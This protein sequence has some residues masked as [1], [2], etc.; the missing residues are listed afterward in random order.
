VIAG[1]NLVRALQST[2]RHSARRPAMLDR[3]RCYTWAEFGGRVARLAGALRAIGIGAGARYAILSRNGF[4]AEELKWAGLWIGALPVPLNWRLAPPEIAHVLADAECRA[5]FA[6]TEFG[7]FFEH[8]AL[9]AW[10]RKVRTFGSASGDEATI[11]ESMVASTEAATEADADPD[12]D[13][14]VLYTGGT[15]GRSKGVRLSHGNILSNALEIGLGMGA[16]PQDVYLHAAPIFHSGDL[17]ATAWLLLGAAHCYLPAY[18]PQVFLET[19]A[20]HRASVL[21]PVPT[22]LIDAIRHPGFSSFDVSGVRIVFYGSAPTAFEWVERFARVFPNA[23]VTTG[24]GLTEAAPI[25]AIFDPRD[26]RAAIEEARRSGRRDGRALSVGK[27]VLLND[28]RIVAAD[29]RDVAAGEVGEIAVRGPNVMKGYLNLPEATE[30]VLKSGWLR[31]GDIGRIDEDGYLYLLDRAKDM[32]ISGGENVYSTEVEQALYRHPAVA[33]AAVIGVPDERLGETVM[34]VVVCAPGTRPSDDELRNH[35]REW[36][37]G[38]K[39]PRRFAFV[40]ALPRSAFGKVLK[41]ALR[42]HL[43][44]DAPCCQLGYVSKVR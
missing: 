40:D 35:C 11:Y 36:L 9:A 41:P 8:P 37:G 4:R 15:T 42:E 29:G 31:T 3:D 7:K 38:F 34:A 27:P 23:D 6:E 26:W 28:L 20:R 24:Y 32:L 22:M 30:E 17:I 44:N 19:I 2:I 14:I 5:I 16:R 21:F 33:E 39:I 13:A 1:S 10:A 18:S 12:E 43:A 25:V